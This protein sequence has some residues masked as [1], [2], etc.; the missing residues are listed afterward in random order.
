MPLYYQQ[1]INEF[2]KMAVWKIEE[3]V[4]FFSETLIVNPL[5]SHPNQQLQHL[6]GRY[7]LKL[8]YPDFP[9]QL[10]QIAASRKPFLPNHPYYFSISHCELF[11]EQPLNHETDVNPQLHYGCILIY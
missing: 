8:L 2:T 11:F 3:S 6:A 4:E 5:I 9:L 10:I 1:N 7:L